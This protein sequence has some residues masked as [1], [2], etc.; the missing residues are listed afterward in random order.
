MRI[1]MAK[2]YIHLRLRKSRFVEIFRTTPAATVC[3]NFFVLSHADGCAFSPHCSYCYLKSS[4]WHLRGQHVFTNV[5]QLLREVSAW[6]AT[7]RLESYILNSGNLSDSLAFEV[8]RPLM[9]DLVELFRHEAEE[10]GRKHTL[11]LVTKGG[12]RE[13]RTLFKLE[14][15]ANVIVSFSVN[16]TRAAQLYE[17]GAPPVAERLEAACRLK[18]LGWRLRIRIDPMIKDFSYERVAGQVARLGPERVTLGTLRAEPNLERYVPK[19]LFASLRPPNTRKGMARYPLAVR[20]ELYRQ[21][22]RKLEG[23]CEIGLCEETPRAWKELGLDP[24]ARTCNC[25]S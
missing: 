5:K 15:C 6:I 16:S 18:C 20:L 17:A 11:L 13:C 7:D 2:N 23:V 24:S 19:N 21:A 22:L 4:L 12:L 10:R 3:P 9:A 1:L 25:G 14:P 8:F